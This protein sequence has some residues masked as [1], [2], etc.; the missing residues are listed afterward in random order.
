M[1]AQ[2]H[3]WYNF[4]FIKF[5][6]FNLSISAETHTFTNMMSAL[7]IRAHRL[8]QNHWCW[9]RWETLRQHQDVVPGG[10]QADVS[11]KHWAGTAEQTSF[12]SPVRKVVFVQMQESWSNVTCH[13]LKNERL[14][15]HVLCSPAALEV[16]LQV[17]LDTTQKSTKH[18]CYSLWPLE[19]SPIFYFNR[20]LKP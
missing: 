6:S 11:R 16:A 9:S 5:Q 20:D 15:G 7:M 4:R 14:G 18:V 17:S 3:T 2:T 10:R 1:H 19:G 12:H 13:L 8:Q